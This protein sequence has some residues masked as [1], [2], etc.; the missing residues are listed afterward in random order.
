MHKKSN[1]IFNDFNNLYSSFP[2]FYT[3]FLFGTSSRMV[4]I[5][6]II[7]N[8]QSQEATN[9]IIISKARWIEEGEKNI[10]FLSLEKK[11]LS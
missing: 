4:D 11:K 6:L 1:I 8:K 9:A 2:L 10:Y 5:S 7:N 3:D